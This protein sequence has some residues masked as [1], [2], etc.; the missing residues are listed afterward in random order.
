IEIWPLPAQPAQSGMGIGDRR[1]NRLVHFM[2]DRG[3][4]LPYRSDAVRV[5][6]FHLHLA[7]APLALAR[8]CFSLLAL[9]QIDDKSDT[10]VPAFLE[11]RSTNQHGHTAAAFAKILLLERL[12]APGHFV[13][14]NPSLFV[15]LEPL[16]RR[17]LRPA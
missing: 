1:G 6:Q 14:R 12:Q 17:Q 11:S 8:L 2:G 13:L 15:E 10:L 9:G 3:R 5:R 16:W 7:V 4:E